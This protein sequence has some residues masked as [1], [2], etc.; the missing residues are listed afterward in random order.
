M[1]VLILDGEFIDQKF[2][3]Y[4]IITSEYEYQTSDRRTDT[5]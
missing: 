1:D 3:L 5:P 2:I 4:L